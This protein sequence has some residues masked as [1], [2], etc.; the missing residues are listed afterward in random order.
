MKRHNNDLGDGDGQ[1]E[2]GPFNAPSSP[3]KPQTVEYD[4]SSLL[5]DLG[6]S[7]LKELHRRPGEVVEQFN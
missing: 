1:W 2:A 6:V 3:Q 7:S 5:D 4:T